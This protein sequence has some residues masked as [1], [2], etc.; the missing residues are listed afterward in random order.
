MLLCFPWQRAGGVFV[1]QLLSK[2]GEYIAAKRHFVS[3]RANLSRRERPSPAAVKLRYSVQISY[4]KN[5]KHRGSGWTHTQK[6]KDKHCGILPFNQ[7]PKA[8]WEKTRTEICDAEKCHKSNTKAD[9]SSSRT[10][11]DKATNQQRDAASIMSQVWGKTG[12]D[13]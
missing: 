10:E 6:K 13:F 11:R 4:E 9:E 8:P 1:Q 3:H 5:N 2:T 12:S 7:K